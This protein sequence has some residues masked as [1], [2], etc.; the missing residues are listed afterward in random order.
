MCR[1]V[2]R[3]RGKSAGRG[4]VLVPRGGLAR[5]RSRGRTA[6]RGKKTQERS[7]VICAAEE[8]RT[9]VCREGSGSAF[10]AVKL[11]S[12]SLGGG[13]PA[14]KNQ[15]IEGSCGGFG[16]NRGC[17][18]L[19]PVQ[20]RV[21]SQTPKKFWQKWKMIRGVGDTAGRISARKKQLTEFDLPS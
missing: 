14:R 5:N 19:R 1:D 6:K 4:R 21:K 18:Q 7:D 12:Q 2:L 8:G 11:L 15:N 10:Q 20:I 17:P 9:G 16:K 13:K 3:G